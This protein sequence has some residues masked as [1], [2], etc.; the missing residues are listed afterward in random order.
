M[1]GG[2]AAACFIIFGRENEDFS[3][4]FKMTALAYLFRYLRSGP[5]QSQQ[6]VAGASIIFSLYIRAKNYA[7]KA[8][9]GTRSPLPEAGL[10][11]AVR[12]NTVPG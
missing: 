5:Y 3:R 11:T 12:P 9:A 4:F 7:E 8:V 10:S 6:R 1:V 2:I